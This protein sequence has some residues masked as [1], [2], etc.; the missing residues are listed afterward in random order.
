MSGSPNRLGSKPWTLAGIILLVMISVAS[1]T[2]FTQA[3]NHWLRIVTTATTNGVMKLYA[4]SLDPS[5][6]VNIVYKDKTLSSS[7]L[8]P[9]F[10]FIVMAGD[11]GA[12]IGGYT[13][14]YYFQNTSAGEPTAIA[15]N[16]TLVYIVTNGGFIALIDKNQLTLPK[17][18]SV[19]INGNLA[20]IR[21]VKV[22]GSYIYLLANDPSF[23]SL[24]VLV[25]D[26][27]LNYVNGFGWTVSGSTIKGVYLDVEGDF[28]TV[29]A[30]TLKNSALV[31]VH[32]LTG[33]LKELYFNLTTT[34]TLRVTSTNTFAGIYDPGTKTI[35][36]A[37][38]LT[39]TNTRAPT[40]SIIAAIDLSEDV[41]RSIA[42]NYSGNTIQLNRVEMAANGYLYAMGTYTVGK[43]YPDLVLVELDYNPSTDPAFTLVKTWRIHGDYEE[44]TNSSHQSIVGDYVYMGGF[45]NSFSDN[46][47]FS[48]LVAHAS[49]GLLADSDYYRWDTSVPAYSDPS[50]GAQV[51]SSFM[52]IETY[53]YVATTS[54]VTSIAGPRVTVASDTIS[55]VNPYS[56]TSYVGYTATTPVPIPEP[57]FIAIAMIGVLL[58]SYTLFRKKQTR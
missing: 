48:L 27:E 45:S 9:Y 34:R 3:S 21:D 31:I 50:K 25:L 57:A 23:Q 32:D 53:T 56:P 38:P 51:N 10:N 2:A 29:S 58:V 52:N 11:T 41:I 7:I 40:G 33:A 37:V 6:D 17:T 20:N 43:D 47:N 18:W 44:Y 49:P 42:L 14:P 5:G 39:N 4:L 13:Y 54:S 46:K 12:I 1:I 16:D 24:Y 55:Y 15:V 36:V 19:S 22:A 28:V 30:L 35:Y 8:Y 26:S